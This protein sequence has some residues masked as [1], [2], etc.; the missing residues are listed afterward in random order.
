MH[1]PRHPEWGSLGQG[2]RSSIEAR[3]LVS[4]SGGVLMLSDF[5]SARMSSL[6]TLETHTPTHTHAQTERGRESYKRRKSAWLYESLLIPE[7]FTQ[8]L[9]HHTAYL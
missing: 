9:I 5:S 1:I 3:R 6:F 7:G 4:A 8:M 2:H